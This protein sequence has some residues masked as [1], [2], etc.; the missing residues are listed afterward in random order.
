M[1]LPAQCM[2]LITAVESKAKAYAARYQVRQHPIEA[3]ALAP[4]TVCSKSCVR[5]FYWVEIL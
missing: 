4:L 2:M 5:Q 3:T 1:Q